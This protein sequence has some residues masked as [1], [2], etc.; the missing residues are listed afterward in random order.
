MA[1]Y[2]TLNVKLSNSQ[3]KDSVWYQI[4]IFKYSINVVLLFKINFRTDEKFNT[5]GIGNN[6]I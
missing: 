4:M 2:N 3:L 5:K 6:G 1:Q